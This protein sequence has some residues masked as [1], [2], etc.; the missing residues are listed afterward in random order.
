M[1]AQA[2]VKQWTPVKSATDKRSYKVFD[3]PNKLRVLLVSDP[4]TDKVH[5]DTTHT[6]TRSRK[7]TQLMFD[8]MVGWCTHTQAGA[9]MNVEVGQFSDPVAIPGLAHFLGSSEQ[10][11]SFHCVQCVVVTCV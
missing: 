7:L 11:P 4:D 3:L 9:A 5:F 6:R 1:A 2:E 10:K 8:W